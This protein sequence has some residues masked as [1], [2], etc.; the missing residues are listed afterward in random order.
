[1]LFEPV[2]HD[3]PVFS[4]FQDLHILSGLICF[5]H[6]VFVIFFKDPSPSKRLCGSLRPCPKE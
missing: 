5:A 3:E 1:M 4:C 6:F 2:L